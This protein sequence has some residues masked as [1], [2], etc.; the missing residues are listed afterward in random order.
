M[1]IHA[2]ISINTDLDN[3]L[4]IFRAP[5]SKKFFESSRCGPTCVC[6]YIHTLT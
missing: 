4:N 5:M 6:K 2:R 1:C 3:F